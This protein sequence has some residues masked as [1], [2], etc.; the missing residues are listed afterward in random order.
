MN[1]SLA[2]ASTVLAVA[3]LFSGCGS[4]TRQPSNI[5][6]G[7]V[8]GTYMFSGPCNAGIDYA[9][10]VDFVT[11]AAAIIAGEAVKV[12]IT[13]LGKAIEKAATDTVE[14]TTVISN[15]SSLTEFTSG[16]LKCVQIVRAHFRYVTN[17]T[18][19]PELTEFG[20][21]AGGFYTPAK[22]AIIDNPEFYAEILPV[23]K[24]GAVAFVP[25]S[26]KYFGYTPS[27][28]DKQSPRDVSLYIGYVETDKNAQTGDFPGRVMDFGVLDAKDSNG[29]T[30]DFVRE[31][32]VL[33]VNQTQFL[34][35]SMDSNDEPFSFAA[36]LIETK[37]AGKIAKFWND[38]F[39]AS[40]DQLK[41]AAVAATAELEIFKTK[42]AIEA[43]KLEEEASRNTAKNE[44]Y[45]AMQLVLA[46]REELKSLCQGTPEASAIYNT[47][48][49]LSNLVNDA[50]L[51]RKKAG[52]HESVLA[53]EP[54]NGQCPP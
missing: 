34:N 38:V 37:K 4:N 23:F 30:L 24:K 14:K 20:A 1:T 41:T 17:T 45:T 6:N 51:K 2:K 33:S 49:Q 43:T 13:Y 50:N 15:Q 10:P 26:V 29:V 16:R 47:Q 48:A 39:S 5:G 9:K 22:L 52:I 31:G 42:Q 18:E 53:V 46:K 21:A 8:F 44:Y 19:K 7:I 36:T 11:E 35:L 32:R 28:Y 27:E 54:V 12:G 25:L 3:A 40:E